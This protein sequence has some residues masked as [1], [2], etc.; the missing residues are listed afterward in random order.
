MTCDY[1]WLGGCLLLSDPSTGESA[2][3]QGQE[4]ED[5][6]DHI[7]DIWGECDLTDAG[8]IEACRLDQEVFIKSVVLLRGE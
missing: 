2:T 7:Q 5:A 4:A 3:L 6:Y 8:D 1:E